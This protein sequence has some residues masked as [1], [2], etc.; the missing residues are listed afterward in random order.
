MNNQI[1]ENEVVKYR[2]VLEGATLKDSVT[3][4]IAENFVGGLDAD[5]QSKVKIVP[6]NESGQQLLF[7]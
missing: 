5:T 3:K 6:I 7:G 2:V 4:Q 1:I